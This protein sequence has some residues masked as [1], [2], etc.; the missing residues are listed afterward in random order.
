VHVSAC[1]RVC[2][3]VSLKTTLMQIDLDRMW[4]QIRWDAVWLCIHHVW[5]RKIHKWVNS[6]ITHLLACPEYSRPPIHLFASSKYRDHRARNTYYP[7][8]GASAGSL[9][10]YHQVPAHILSSIWRFS[11]LTS[12]VPPSTCSHFVGATSLPTYHQV[13]AYILPVPPHFQRTTKYLLTSCRCHLSNVK[14]KRETWAGN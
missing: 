6:Y 13:P 4:V 1:A 10:T 7:A 2:T 3:F 5:C 8:V 9:P 12:N 11:K 14:E